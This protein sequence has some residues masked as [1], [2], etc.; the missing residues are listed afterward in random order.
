M[1]T[2]SL[3]AL[4][5][6]LFRSGAPAANDAPL[7]VLAVPGYRLDPLP[8]GPPGVGRDDSHSPVTR[9]AV[10]PLVGDGG[11]L[12]L[13]LMTVRSRRHEGFELSA[14]ASQYPSL[15][16]Q[17]QQTRSI[18]NG[19]APPVE[20]AIGLIGEAQALQT[21]IVRGGRAAVTRDQLFN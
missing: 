11:S 21:C 1:A 15:R 9:Y 10:T 6:T 3:L 4:L 20:L 8:G 14:L 16:L 19:Q 12:T 7:G 5:H 13:T 18:S 17:G 2:L